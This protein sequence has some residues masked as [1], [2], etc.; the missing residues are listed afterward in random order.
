MAH[1]TR[2]VSFE[3]KFNTNLFT[4]ILPS[5]FLLGTEEKLITR[6]FICRHIPFAL[7]FVKNG[8]QLNAFLLHRSRDTE[9]I[10][11][12]LDLS[13]TLLC[14]EHFT[15]NETFI[16]KNCKF[17]NKV[18]LHGRKSFTSV[19]RLCSVDYM[20]ERGNIQCELE[21][22]NLS[23]SYITDVQLTPQLINPQYAHVI[24][25]TNN[26]QPIDAKIETPSFFY[27]NYEWCVVIQPKLDSVGQLGHFR[28]FIQR[29]TPCDHS[30]K[31]T[32]RVKLIAG[33]YTW[34]PYQERKIT[35]PHDSNT[36]EINY[37]DVHGLC[38]PYRIDR[39]RELLQADGK[40]TLTV[41]LKDAVTVFPIIVD[42][43][44]PNPIPVSFL[45][46]DQQA[47]TVEA[48]IE[49]QCFI[50]RLYYSD[51]FKIPTDYVRSICFNITVRN[52]RDTKITTSVFPK[53][54]TKYYSQ[55]DHDEGLEISTTLDV[56][57]LTQRGYLNEQQSV[58]IEIEIFF[59]HLMYSPEYTPLDDIVRKQKQQIMRE[60]QTAQN[61]NFQLEKKLHEIQMSIQNPTMSS[62]LSD[63]PNGP[64][65]GIS[66]PTTP[67]V[68]R[69]Y[70][71]MKYGD[72]SSTSN[73]PLSMSSNAT[74]FDGIQSNINSLPIRNGVLSGKGPP[75]SASSIPQPNVTM[76]A[77]NTPF[78]FTTKLPDSIQNTIANTSQ[79]LQSK[80]PTSLQKLPA[81][82]T[83]GP[84][85]N[86][87][88]NKFQN[89]FL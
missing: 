20:D 7:T 50:I 31:L 57:E 70:Y 6:E 59:S 28:M 82:F 38:R 64:Q 88:A 66:A 63:I 14:R 3:D 34:D 47:W 62:R 55:K 74:S 69:K 36:Y 33:S 43:F 22:K 65:S 25:P 84:T 83:Q 39:V 26:R 81:S 52:Y 87:L 37:T 18:T 4:F 49:E 76:G 73:P 89:A 80:L 51:I 15:R 1:F 30:V 75:S 45:D 35:H 10:E 58:T 44:A 32:Y 46:K 77:R 56:D 19:N 40:F 53:P 42:P 21:I 23:I 5:T 27:S 71:E 67:N 72:K 61:E 54:V 68:V 86:M 17:T 12:T 48:Y 11:M 79:S 29:L 60:L 2:F 24:H 8:D 16:E 78:K 41:E 9:R 85:I 13:V